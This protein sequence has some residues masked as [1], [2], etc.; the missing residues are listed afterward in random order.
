MTGPPPYSPSGIT[1]SNVAY[2]RGWSSVGMASRF[3]RGSVDGP[4]GTAHDFSTPSASSRKSQCI[5]VASCCWIT[6]RGFRRPERRPGRPPAGSG[7]RR[8]SRF[9]RYSWRESVVGVALVPVVIVV[10][11]LSLG[12]ELQPALLWRSGLQDRLVE[13]LYQ[14]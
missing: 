11:Q 13:R 9:R 1:P 14:L 3:S 12:T 7:V 6:K 10:V 2:S 5:A 4:F 8:R